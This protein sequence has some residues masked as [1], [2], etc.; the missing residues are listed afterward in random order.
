M[1]TRAMI[2]ESTPRLPMQPYQ[3]IRWNTYM[4]GHVFFVWAIKIKP[5][6]NVRINASC[7][8][9]NIPRN[10]MSYDWLGVH[11]LL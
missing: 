9:S 7:V 1:T 3:P 2:Q 6:T 10:Y 4:K 8:S 5:K 11:L